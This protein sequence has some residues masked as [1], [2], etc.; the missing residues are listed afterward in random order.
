MCGI[1]GIWNYRGS[2]P[3]DELIG[4]MLEAMQHRGPDSRGS[5]SFAGGAAGMVRLALVDP[6]PR[7]EQPMFSPCGKVAIVFN[8]EIYN[9]REERK[10]LEALG[11]TFCSTTDTEVLLHTYLECGEDFVHHL[12]GMFAVAI[13]DWRHTSLDAPPTVLL[14]RGPLGV[15]PLYVAHVGA[16]RE[17]IVFSSE[18]RS[19][20]ASGLVPQRVDPS[21]VRDYLQYGFVLQPRTMIEGVRMLE[22][23]TIERF[24]PGRPRFARRYWRVPAYLPRKETFAEAAERLRGELEESVR[25][26]A[27][28]DVPVGAFLSGGIDSTS[29]VALMRKH[30]SQLRTYTF[31]FPEFADADES[32]P[33]ALTA[34]L[35]DCHHTTVDV[36]GTDVRRLLP[37]F[38]DEIDQPSFDGL[39]SWFVSRRAAEDVKAVVSGL[40]GDEWFAGYP[41]TSRMLR[42]NMRLWRRAG[43]LAGWT[44]DRLR[45]FVAD[46]SL[47]RRLDGLAARRSALSIW[48]QPHTVFEP[49]EVTSLTGLASEACGLQ[50]QAEDIRSLI[51]VDFADET[52][53]GMSCLLDVYVFEMCQLLRDADATSMSCSL[54][55]RVPFVDVKLAEFSRTCRDD[56]K[57]SLDDCHGGGANG[58]AKKVL[59]KAVEDLLP[60]HVRKQ[61]KRGFV[62]PIERWMQTDLRDLIDDTCRPDVVKQRGLIDPQAV[63]PLFKPRNSNSGRTQFPQLWSLMVLELW[64]R[65]VL[66]RSFT[67]ATQH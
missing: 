55:L 42:R 1:A 7:G 3:A 9:F 12:R 23:A 40:G 54:E 44:A 52:P 38:A 22:P 47:R 56:Y 15:K 48:M 18:L 51:G 16:H 30:V 60:E 31:R 17:T 66:D 19:L 14:A 11:H 20:L 67:P 65:A 24:E 46:G 6:T 43:S 2:R 29:I 53:V 35:F 58:G 13:F 26:H 41:V 27:F 21:A 33:A 5:T 49:P 50:H 34:K 36:T 32:E 10:R 39:N 45:G 28:A 59:V 62:L 37:T 8:G 25:L 61:P 57:L 63:A 64:S 4:D